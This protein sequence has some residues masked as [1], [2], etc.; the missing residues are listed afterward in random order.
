MTIVPLQLFLLFVYHENYLS[1]LILWLN[2]LVCFLLMY[3]IVCEISGKRPFLEL[4]HVCLKGLLVNDLK[5]IISRLAETKHALQTN[6]PLKPLT[7][8][9]D[10]TEAWNKYLEEQIKCSDKP[11]SWFSS[12]WLY[13]ECFFY[14]KIHE[15]MN[16]RWELFG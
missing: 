1:I 5:G 15:A 11:P 3:I 13:I 4:W 6:K 8:N 2:S 9:T 10:S 12:T 14:R 16:L 7:D